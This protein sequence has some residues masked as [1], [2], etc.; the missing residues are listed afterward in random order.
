MQKLPLI[1]EFIELHVEFIK[2]YSNLL[3]IVI[4]LNYMIVVNYRILRVVS[5]LYYF[6]DINRPWS[7]VINIKSSILKSS[8]SSAMSKHVSLFT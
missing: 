7:N 5:L 6:W 3:I 1:K 4:W 2:K 8:K